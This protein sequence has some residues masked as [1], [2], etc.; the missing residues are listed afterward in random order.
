MLELIFAGATELLCAPRGR[1]IDKKK[2]NANRA[3]MYPHSANLEE[4]CFDFAYHREDE[5][6]ING[7][8]A[9]IYSH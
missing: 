6:M 7:Q 2:E 4:A 9:T 5:S 1:D 3:F 8:P